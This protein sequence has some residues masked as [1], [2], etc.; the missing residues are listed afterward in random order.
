MVTSR[1][2]MSRSALRKFN[3]VKYIACTYVKTRYRSPLEVSEI[4]QV[5]GCIPI[6]V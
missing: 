4:R 3:S 2:G 1:V 6:R 5:C